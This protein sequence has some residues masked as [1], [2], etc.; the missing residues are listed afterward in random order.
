MGGRGPAEHH[1]HQ[2]WR[3]PRAALPPPRSSRAPAAAKG[4]PQ[5]YDSVHR[6]PQV[7][8]TPHSSL[9]HG[10]RFVCV[11]ASRQE[12]NH[13]RQQPD[14]QRKTQQSSLFPGAHQC[15]SLPRQSQHQVHG[16][17][18]P[19]LLSS[20][21]RN[22]PFCL[23]GKLFQRHAHLSRP[24]LLMCPFRRFHLKGSKKICCINKMEDY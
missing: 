21:V 16:S 19:P 15:A 13:G 9:L 22:L 10:V 3:R 24:R 2:Q 14:L 1:H 17:S 23:A 11:I 4:T 20:R 5:T 6:S 12:N 8:D 18:W 7:G